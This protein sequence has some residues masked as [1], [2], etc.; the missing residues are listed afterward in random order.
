NTSEKRYSDR[1]EPRLQWMA[2]EDSLEGK[3]VLLVDDIAGDGGTMAFALE[4][5]RSR[6]PAA[7]RAAVVVRNANSPYHPDYH[8]IVVNDWIVFPWEPKVED[9]TARVEPISL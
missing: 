3:S 4:L 9:G 1:K 7:L 8:A 2:P 5:V 6:R